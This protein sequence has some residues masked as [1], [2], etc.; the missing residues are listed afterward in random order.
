MNPFQRGNDIVSAGV[1]GICIFLSK[2]GKV[3]RDRGLKSFVASNKG[4]KVTSL[5]LARL[6]AALY[7]NDYLPSDKEKEVLKKCKGIK[8]LSKEDQS[9]FASYVAYGLAP[10]STCLQPG[11]I[12]SRKQALLYTDHLMD[13]QTGYDIRHPQGGVGEISDE[14]R[15]GLAVI[16][17]NDRSRSV[18]DEQYKE[19]EKEK[20]LL[21]KKLQEKEL[22][23][24][25]VQEK[26]VPEK[27]V[28]EKETQQKQDDTTEST[29][30]QKKQDKK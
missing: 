23:E 19:S 20:K 5:R 8:G 2:I 3:K 1:S 12:I 22:Q 7:P 18:L 21:E 29:D 9:A 6:H 17:L 16:S 25:E 15:L 24:K 13:Y 10:D 14:G 4:G 27:Q 26:E 11:Q 28:Q 30:N